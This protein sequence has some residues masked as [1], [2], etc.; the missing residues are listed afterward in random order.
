MRID[1]AQGSNAAQRARDR[2]A[3]IGGGAFSLEEASQPARSAQPGVTTRIGSVDAL[4]A[5]Q[6]VEERDERSVRVK[7]GHEM[8]DLLDDLRIGIL[9]GTLP[10]AKLARL[11]AS[12]DRRPERR[13]D[14]RIEDMLDEIELRAKVELAKLGRLAA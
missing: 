7:H 4:I 9:G 10:A 8:L 6:A 12:L 13:E 5:L 1:G 3:K 14:T 2:R 11:V